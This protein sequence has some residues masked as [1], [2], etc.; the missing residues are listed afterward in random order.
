MGA[1]ERIFHPPELVHDPLALL[2]RADGPGFDRSPAGNN[3]G[4]PL[5]AADRL[6]GFGADK[7]AHDLVDDPGILDAAEHNRDRPDKEC[8]T[9]ELFQDEALGCQR[10]QDLF[11]DRGLFEAPVQDNR[12][13]Q[14]LRLPALRFLPAQLLVQDTLVGSMLV[15][16]EQLF[17]G[18]AGKDIDPPEFTDN[19]DI[20]KER[21]D[22]VRRAGIN[23]QFCL[24][25]TL[26]RCSG[27]CMCVSGDN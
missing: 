2:P 15:D 18:C 7:I 23:R 1:R 21:G 4:N 8:V 20:R 6:C 22:Q 27:P 19:P 9:A 12:A 10:R 24:P 3:P 11:E 16:Q 17:A 14:F 26:V 13:D 5:A 25:E